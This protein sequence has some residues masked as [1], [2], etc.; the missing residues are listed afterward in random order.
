MA[1]L[2]NPAFEDAAAG[3]GHNGGHDGHGHEKIEE[4]TVDTQRGHG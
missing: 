4:H 2:R 3:H 1:R